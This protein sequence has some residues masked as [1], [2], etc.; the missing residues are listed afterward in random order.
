[1]TVQK[2][3]PNP[4]IRTQPYQVPRH[5]ASISLKLDS[6]EGKAPPQAILKSVESL[7]TEQLLRYPNPARL[8]SLLAARFGI[9]QKSVLLT[10]GGDEGLMRM[11]R[12]F[13][14]PGRNMI[15]PEPSFEMIRR[16]AED[17]QAEVRTVPYPARGYPTDA[18]IS[19]CD[20]HT[21]VI[22][23]VS[24]NNPTGGVITK[25]DLLR[26]SKAVPQ[27]MLML[28]LAYVEFAEHDLTDTALEL[29]NVVIFRT[30]SKAFGLA[31]LRVGYAMGPER[32]ITLLRSVGLPYPVSQTALRLAEC[33]LGLSE[34]RDNTVRKL[35]S[36]RQTI[37]A[38]L[39]KCNIQSHPSQ[40]N[41]VFS[42]GVDGSWWRDAMAGL[43]IGIRAW[44]GHQTLKQAIRISCPTNTEDTTRLC[45]AIE[46]ISSPQ[47]LIFDM[48]GVLADVARSYR[49]AIV[50]TARHFGAEIAA[51]D[52]ER[53]KS[54]GDANNDWVVTW[55]LLAEQD[56]AVSLESVTD[57]FEQ[58]YQ[59]IGTKEGLYKKERFIGNAEVLAHLGQRYKLGIV[60]GRPRQDAERFLRDFG[61]IDRF[62]T[63]ICMED[64]PC[65]PSPKP[66]YRA[67]EAMGVDRAWMLGDTPDDMV[68]AREAG[69]LPIGVVP[70][71]VTAEPLGT[72][73]LQS[74]AS[75]V[76]EQW[77][78]I[79]GRLP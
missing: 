51:S 2:P 32:W 19:K 59:G 6:N 11:C 57:V 77:D 9:H 61:L 62:E 31:G 17:T 14:G 70:P 15:F 69:V 64:A 16:F 20:E 25:D 22:A 55:R 50:R 40:A 30:F 41:F 49:A 36:F 43:G 10:A 1:M 65:K 27:A 53:I 26:L 12:A 73:L 4:W 67:L 33:C 78:S 5:P 28:D 18:V 37:A 38:T 24:P 79:L 44:P 46:T 58:L 54:N 45:R 47:A 23:V 74:G 8:E 34:D 13:L 39:S 60:T 66:V 68:A 75:I 21:A 29:S 7:T 35:R 42:T 3:T 63:V 56:I 76:L 52:I 72:T 71:G 48:D